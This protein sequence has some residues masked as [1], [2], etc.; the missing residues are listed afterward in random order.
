MENFTT[1][2][3]ARTSNIRQTVLKMRGNKCECCGIET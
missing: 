2:S 1:D 3:K